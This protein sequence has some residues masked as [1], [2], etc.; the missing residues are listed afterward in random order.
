[1]HEA[2]VVIS[3]L[4]VVSIFTFSCIGEGQQ[5]SIFEE[6]GDAPSKLWDSNEIGEQWQIISPNNSTTI[7]SFSTNDSVDVFALEISST[8]WTMVGFWVSNNDTVRISVQRL[9]QSTWTI[10]EFADSEQ[11]EL[12]LDPGVHAIRLERNGDFGEEIAYRFTLENRGSFEDEGEFVNLAWMFTPF[13]VVAGLF[14]I[15]PL[16]IVLWWNRS[17]LLP[18][19]RGG[20]LV[21]NERHILNALRDRFSIKDL[22][23]GRE[24]VSAAL[25][26]LGKGSWNSVSEELG[27]PEIRHFTENIDICV[28]RFEDSI[29]SLL[30]GIRAGTIGWEMA[31][32][33]IFSPLGEVAT[34]QSVIPEMIFR[35]DEVFLGDLEGGSTKFVQIETLGNPPAFNI[36]ISGLVDGKPIAAVPTNPIEMGEE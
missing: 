11:G 22:T 14:L 2:R 35:D 31:A 13:Y 21:E 8:N 20:E 28:W 10:V 17:D 30:I 25:S 33:R 7:G 9:N 29:N 19:K 5:N 24:E 27:V 15:F 16:V 4:I 18:S 26:I 1:M 34:I 12:G 36:Q 23:K 3:T 32:I 6:F